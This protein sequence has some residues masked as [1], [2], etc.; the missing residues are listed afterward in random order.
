MA[1]KAKGGVCAGLLVTV[2]ASAAP[3]DNRHITRT[4]TFNATVA[5]H[6]VVR[7]FGTRPK[8]AG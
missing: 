6:L 3:L 1:T 4:R 8:K 5:R 2:L 7:G